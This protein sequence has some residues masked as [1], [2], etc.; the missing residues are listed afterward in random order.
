MWARWPTL[1]A[2][3]LLRCCA[4]PSSDLRAPERRRAA[5]EAWSL[6]G[7]AAAP[8]RT[9]P[10]RRLAVAF[11]RSSWRCSG[12]LGVFLE[13]LKSWRG[14]RRSAQ[15]L[16]LRI[17]GALT[18]WK[19]FASTAAD[20]RRVQPAAMLAIAHLLTPSLFPGLENSPNLLFKSP[21]DIY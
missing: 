17:D 14:P 7:T 1:P 6:G 3:A 9:P 10:L 13:G 19:R 8:A 20:G 11:V 2:A 16:P 12:R 21:P 5:E 18:P 4:A 15:T